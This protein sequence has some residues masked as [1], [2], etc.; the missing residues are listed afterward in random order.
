M[1]R[2]IDLFKP[3][4]RGLGRAE[5]ADRLLNWNDR[6]RGFVRFAN[7]L[8]DAGQLDVIVATGDLIDF[9]FET[10]DDPWAAALLFLRELVL[11]TAPAPTSNVEELR[12]PIL[13]TPGNHDYR[14]NPTS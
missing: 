7:A 8:H 9:Q 11:G 3:T 13:M 6:F 12:V 4:L 1:A 2:R 14:H 10:T 5:A